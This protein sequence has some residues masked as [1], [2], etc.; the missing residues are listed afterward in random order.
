MALLDNVWYVDATQGVAAASW[1]TASAAIT[2]ATAPPAG[3][4]NNSQTVWDVPLGE[5]IGVVSTW[6]GTTLTLTTNPTHN[7]SGSADLLGFENASSYYAVAPY[8]N[9]AWVAG[10]ILRQLTAPAVGSERC[11]VVHVG[12]TSTGEPTWAVTRGAINA[13][14]GAGSCIEATGVAALNGDLT[15]T[16]T[17]TQY[18][19]ATATA[20][21]GQVI[22][23]GD[24]TK[25]LI[26]RTGGTM[27]ALGSE[28]T[29]AAYTTAGATTND[30]ATPAVW[31]TIAAVPSGFSKWAAPFA[32]LSSSFVASWGEAGNT[33]FVAS[34]HAETTAA[35]IT[36]A[37]PG[38]SATS[39]CNVLCVDK[40]NVPPGSATTGASIAT[41][42]ASNITLG[43][44]VKE[45][46]SYTGISFT[47]ANSTNAGNINL[48][49]GPTNFMTFTNCAFTLGGTASASVFQ[50]SLVLAQVVLNNC[51]FTFGAVGQSIT[52]PTSSGGIYIIRGGSMAASGSV[53]T[54][55]FKGVSPLTVLDSVD[56]G[57]V[58]TTL[59]LPSINTGYLL[60]R[61]CKLNASVA[62]YGRAGGIT[63][64]FSTVDVIRS[65]SS[66]ANYRQE[67]HNAMADLTTE[68]TIVRTSGAQ[69]TG[70]GVSWNI[71]TASL[72]AF[73]FP[74]ESFLVG[75]QNATTAAN[76]TL[77]VYGIW[78]IAALPN[79]D[80]IWI[81]GDY[82]GS[83]S[84]PVGTVINNT[85]AN[86]L[87][88]GSPLTADSTS[89]WGA[90]A[91]AYQTSHAY[92]AFTGVILAG[93]ASP[94]Q[95][96]F[97]SSHSGTGTSGSDPTIFNG[98]ADGAQVTDNAGA[99]QIVWQAMTRFSM[100]FTMSSPQPAQKGQINVRVKAALATS[101]FYVDPQPV[102]A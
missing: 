51:T 24:G 95:L 74:F 77:T 29:W 80:Q 2:M 30:G 41:T 34:E 83:A 56:L 19:T 46:C 58:N 53:P 65:D 66:G 14:T 92:G 54:D 76:V 67:R 90:G 99:N 49:D 8:A 7:S 42:G 26:C 17:W 48:A 15:N 35:S 22:K 82:L 102:L 23:S 9:Q 43:F 40:T 79:N 64:A 27:A 21:G 5:T 37:S 1:T 16:P 6:S 85:K 3:W 36:F 52:A 72:I 55:L 50:F 63:T 12:G 86:L 93:N 13:F 84:S 89:P 88:S 39:P 96:W 60:I 20:T 32:H 45:W 31:V 18:R 75:I 78:K 101:T 97:M 98:K 71:T 94:R 38:T 91:A 68:T 44:T 57:A 61:D 28:P 59:Y 81:E 11:F 69:V 33:F 100:A 4:V 25:V 62:V 73:E 47:A 87:A 10:N 70:T